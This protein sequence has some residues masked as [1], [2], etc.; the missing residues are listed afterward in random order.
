MLQ[1]HAIRPYQARTHQLDHR[2]D[3]FGFVIQ[4]R[5]IRKESMPV[6]LSG[7]RIQAQVRNFRV[8]KMMRVPENFLSVSLSVKSRSVNLLRAGRAA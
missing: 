1:A 4:I 5:L 6:V 2:I 3:T 7:D 8:V